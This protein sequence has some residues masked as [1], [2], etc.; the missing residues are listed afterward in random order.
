[1]ADYSIHYFEP[2]SLL[3]AHMRYVGDD[4]DADMGI[5]A[6][7]PETHRW[8]QVSVT[9]GPCRPA[10]VWIGRYVTTRDGSANSTDDGRHA[11]ELCAR[12]CG[13]RVW[14]RMVDVRRRGLP[15]GR[16]G[17]RYIQWSCHGGSAQHRRGFVN[18]I[19]QMRRLLDPLYIPPRGATQ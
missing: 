3:I 9:Y 7:D 12:R 16:L 19:F 14:P 8:W 4:Y 2:L 13:Q 18:T 10:C 11:R 5:I 6:A 1:M 17:A 15:D